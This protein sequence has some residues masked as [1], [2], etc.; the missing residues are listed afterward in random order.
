MGKG[1]G[2]S[3]LEVGKILA[4]FLYLFPAGES[5]VLYLLY[6][7]VFSRILEKMYP[8]AALHNISRQ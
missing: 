2:P 5:L 6:T 4:V 7:V 8:N 1:A 3:A